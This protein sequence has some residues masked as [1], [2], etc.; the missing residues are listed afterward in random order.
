M[1][2]KLN[3]MK[4]TIL[5]FLMCLSMTLTA[6]TV[7]YENL[8][9]FDKIVINGE[10]EQMTINGSHGDKP[11][12]MIKG[13]DKELTT[14]KIE[15]GVYYI[16]LAGQKAQEIEVYNSN[17]HRIETDNEVAISGADIVGSQGKYLVADINH[18]DWPKMRH[19][20]IDVPNIDVDIAGLDIDIPEIDIDFDHDFDFNFDVP[21]VDFDES[22]FH[23]D[24][25]WEE[26]REEIRRV[27]REVKEEVKS[28]MEE[29]KR[30]VKKHKERK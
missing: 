2:Q 12:V 3:N 6:Q 13:I 25:N 30:E 10:V 1:Y 9:D 26:H 5:A 21:E 27:S 11:V 28:A 8:G 14:T 23:F 17:L 16:D 19:I 18:G 20:D 15:A 4:T 24:W 29:V 22:D 7:Q